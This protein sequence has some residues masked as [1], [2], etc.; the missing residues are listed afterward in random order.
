M[1]LTKA[2]EMQMI[3]EEFR[4]LEN[5][6]LMDSN[7]TVDIKE[8]LNPR[9]NYEAIGQFASDLSIPYVLNP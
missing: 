3:T 1:I 8:N 7:L 4:A 5:F 9:L 6:F 2:D